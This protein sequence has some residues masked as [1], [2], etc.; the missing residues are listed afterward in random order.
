MKRNQ[1]SAYFQKTF[2]SHEP[3]NAFHKNL[4][5][6]LLYNS[7][8]EPFWEVDQILFIVFFSTSSWGTKSA[9]SLGKGDG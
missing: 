4:V 2:I 1:V 9:A 6:F 5:T 7:D 3:N 8:G